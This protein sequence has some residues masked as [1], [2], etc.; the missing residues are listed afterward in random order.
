MRKLGLLVCALSTATLLSAAG[1]AY[2]YE[3]TPVIGGVWK[4]GNLNLRDEA[5]IGAEFQFNNVDFFLKPEISILYS[6]GVDYKSGSGDTSIT[7]LMVNGVH[8]YD[9]V[10]DIIP[11][12]KAG[13]GFEY[14]GDKKSD[15]E[16]S[17]FVDAGAGLKFPLTDTLAL[18]TEVIYMLK[19]NDNRWDNNLA[20]LV[21]LT[22]S[23]G[24]QAEATAVAV[25]DGDNDGVIDA[26]DQCPTTPEGVAVDA[27]GCCLDGDKDGVPDHKD[28][29]PNTPA[30][31][32]VDA[33]GCCLD[34]DNDGV[35][36]YKDKCPETPAGVKVDENGCCLD[37]DKDGVPD[38]KD[39][40]PDTPFGF[41]VDGV[42]CPLS[43]S[44]ALT[45]EHDSAEIDAASMPKVERFSKFME[46]NKPYKA[47][48]IGYTD[49]SGSEAYNQK[50]SDRRAASV[51]NVLLKHGVA[52][53][54]LTHEGRGEANPMATNDTEEGRAA[55]RRIE[56]VLTH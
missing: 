20:G 28:K 55:N 3:L 53:E 29:C 25:L 23:F 50:L 14:M 56:V 26:D 11:F 35:P 41:K 17:C 39:K 10:G 36:N 12:T 33:D 5:T 4:E 49:S 40:C 38:Y 34:D 52:P 27:V 19:R 54:R 37:S 44:L 51:I 42:G 9:M 8:E 24:K 15:N 46:E 18:K 31:V 30:G 16:N 47:Q 45:Y 48:V 7:R 43:L 2:D 1:S 21:G 6:P 22:Y 13:V 32:A